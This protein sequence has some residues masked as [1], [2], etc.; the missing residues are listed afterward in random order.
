MKKGET[1]CYEC[2]KPGHIKADCPMLKKNDHKKKDSSK[3]FRRYK[4]KAMAAA[5]ENSSDSD[6]ESSSSSDGEEANL[7]LMANIEE[8]S[9]HSGNDSSSTFTLSHLSVRPKP[10]T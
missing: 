8:K 2:K 7:A 3:K 9:N 1:I 6:S 10:M 5:W 4:K